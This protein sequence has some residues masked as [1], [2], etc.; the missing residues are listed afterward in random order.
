MIVPQLELVWE[1]SAGTDN[2][3]ANDE[4]RSGKMTGGK[5]VGEL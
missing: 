3:M 2:N 4:N 5:I 1:N